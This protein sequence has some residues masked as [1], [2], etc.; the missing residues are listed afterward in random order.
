MKYSVEISQEAKDDIL[1][2]EKS[3]DKGSL[4]KLYKLLEELEQHPKSGTGK[5]EQLKHFS[6]PT[7]SRRISQKHRLIYE[8]QEDK[9]VVLVLSAYGH[10]DNN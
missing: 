1:R 3:G 9:V 6:K 2:L 8:I 5:P 7:W 10:Y 4:R